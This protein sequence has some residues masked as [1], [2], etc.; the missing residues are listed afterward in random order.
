MFISL[1]GGE[2]SGKTTQVERLSDALA[3][4][5]VPALKIHEPGYTE[6]GDHL[7]YLIKSKPW[8]VTISP[9]AELF[10]FAASRGELVS[11]VLSRKMKDPRLVIIADRYADSTIAYQG[12]GRRLPLAQVVAVNQ[13][14][15]GGLMPIKTF[16]LDCPPGRGLQ[17]VDVQAH[18][19]DIE[20]TGRADQDGARRFED[21]PLSF[22]DRVRT[23]YRAL[24]DREPDR[25]EVIDALASPDEVFQSIWSVIQRMDEFQSILNHIQDVPALLSAYDSAS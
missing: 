12:Y 18:L 10:L 22:H 25:W 5:G 8:G 2:G 9:A 7:R 13:L 4:L 17:R 14:A 16:L 6:L 1:E 20:L 21:E 11:K 23:G 24:A 19:F 15:T 3:K